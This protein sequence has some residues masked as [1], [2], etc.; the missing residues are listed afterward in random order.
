R[1]ATTRPCRP[2]VDAGRP[3]SARLR[4][5]RGG[6]PRST[7][8]RRRRSSKSFLYQDS[9][10]AFQAAPADEA[11]GAGGDMQAPGNLRVGRRRLLVEKEGNHLPAAGRQL[12]NRFAEDLL[13]L[14]LCQDV[15]SQDTACGDVGRLRG[16]CFLGGQTA[17][18][19]V[20]LVGSDAD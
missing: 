15:R 4:F 3:S 16:S 18:P 19:M 20:A 17:F 13:T 6:L 9:L 11:D 7:A 5:A 2:A 14:Q 12:S 1:D 10:Q 8:A